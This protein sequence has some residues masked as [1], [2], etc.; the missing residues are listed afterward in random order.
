MIR[1]RWGRPGR[2]VRSGFVMCVTWLLV[3]CAVVPAPGPGWHPHGL[4]GKAPT[5][6]RWTVKDGLGAW[7]AVAQ[8]SASLMRRQLP[9]EQTA[10]TRVEFSWWVDELISAADIRQAEAD[11]APVRVIFAFD[12]DRAKLSM[13]NRML[14][15]LAQALTGEPLP[16]AT[17]VYAW[18][19]RAP[20]DDVVVSPRSDRIRT[21]VVESGGRHLKQWRH[22]QRDLAADFRRAFGEDPGPLMGLAVMTDADNTASRAEAWYGDIRLR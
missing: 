17:L 10:P 18:D 3:A 21:V 19:G 4:P 9:A 8:R 2:H 11:D 14:S 13:R 15:E 12:G 22:Y 6:Y 16:Y 1:I 20:L 5:S 7:H